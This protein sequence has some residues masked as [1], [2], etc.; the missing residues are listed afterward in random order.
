MTTLCVPVFASIFTE[1][2]T[3]I[4]YQDGPIKAPGLDWDIQSPEAGIM[5]M[6][7]DLRSTRISVA[8]GMYGSRGLSAAIYHLYQVRDSNDVVNSKFMALAHELLELMRG[9]IAIISGQQNMVQV[10]AECGIQ[11]GSLTVL[12]YLCHRAPEG[13]AHVTSILV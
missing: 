2:I 5:R 12:Q 7:Q 11:P 4:E 9:L 13:T 10:A 6:F 1:L 3:R 8:L